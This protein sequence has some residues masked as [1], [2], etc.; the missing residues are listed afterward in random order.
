MR[1]IAPVL[2]MFI[3]LLIL[4]GISMAIL[5]WLHPQWLSVIALGLGAIALIVLLLLLTAGRNIPNPFR[6]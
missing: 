2:G 5:A 3:L 4:G 1:G 6:Q